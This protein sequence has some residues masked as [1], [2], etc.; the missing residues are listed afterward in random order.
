M[1][2]QRLLL[3]DDSWHQPNRNKFHNKSYLRR[4]LQMFILPSL[5][6][7]VKGIIRSILKHSISLEITYFKHILFIA[8]GIEHFLI[9]RIVKENSNMKESDKLWSLL[10]LCKQ[11][12]DIIWLIFSKGKARKENIASLK[13]YK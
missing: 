12:L 6:R 13:L 10:L 4:S 5:E 9:H 1:K 11:N 8:F 2:L 7:L 3:R